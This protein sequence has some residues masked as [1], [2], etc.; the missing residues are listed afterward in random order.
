MPRQLWG[1]SASKMLRGTWKHIRHDALE[2]AS[3]SCQK[4]GES[5]HPIYGDD[6]IC[7]ELWRYDDQRGV[8]RLVGFEIHCAKCDLVTHMGRALAR[9]YGNEA[10]KQLS[11]VNGITNVEAE[12]V[13]RQAKAVWQKRSAR[14]W[15]IAVD[16]ALLV[17]YPRLGM[18]EVSK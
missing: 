17:R 11:K 4:C 12:R 18:L 3:R 9:G 7:H 13:Y 1:F 16:K 2:T 14:K 5:P 6:L 15:R 10:L 8:A